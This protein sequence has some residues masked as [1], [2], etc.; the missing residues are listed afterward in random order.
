MSIAVPGRCDAIGYLV[1][2]QWQ[3]LLCSSHIKIVDTMS[4][5]RAF[6]TSTTKGTPLSAQAQEMARSLNPKN[7]AANPPR[8]GI[9]RKKKLPGVA[10][11]YKYKYRQLPESLRNQM[12]NMDK[13][14]P[15]SVPVMPRQPTLTVI[16]ADRRYPVRR[17][18][19]VGSNYR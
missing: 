1:D 14:A 17:V 15:L 9:H 19:C 5:R 3:A 18:Y 12:L 16:G 13:H 6:C 4:Y 8:G 10:Y 2:I 7:A 11:H